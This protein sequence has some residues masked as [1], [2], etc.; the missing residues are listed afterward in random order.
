MNRI[1]AQQ[2]GGFPLE[3]DTLDFLQNSFTALQSLVAL[4]GDNFI[5]SGCQVQANNVSAGWV[6]I[7]GELLPFKAGLLQTKVVIIE[8]K[9]PRN[10]ENGTN[11]VVF[12]DRYAQFGTGD[13][14]VLFADLAR[15]KDL[16]TFRNLPGQVSSAIDLDSDL[17]IATSKAV[18]AVYDALKNQIKPGMIMIWPGS[19][20]TIPEGWGMCD[21]ADGRPDLRNF[22]IRGAGDRFAVG[23]DG[24]E[25]THTLTIAEIPAH[26]HGVTETVGGIDFG[27]GSSRNSNTNAYGA[28][29]ALTGSGM[30][31]N[32]VP[33]FIALN[34]IIKL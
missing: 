3:T 7:N 2:S 15:I 26:D 30:P 33:P 34:Y 32:N 22:F 9:A 31:H 1:D 4:G 11:K 25:E 17:H 16:K 20:E 29:T 12:Y 23:E 27:S 5:V 18:K 6:V 28:K 19:K 14:F 21:G 8:S 24:G 13:S 10:F